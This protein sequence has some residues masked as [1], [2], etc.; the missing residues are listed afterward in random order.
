MLMAASTCGAAIGTVIGYVQIN[1]P[2]NKQAGGFN[3]GLSTVTTLCFDD[4]TCQSTVSNGS[5]SGGTTYIRNGYS[6]RFNQNFSVTTTTG[7][8][9]AIFVFSYQAPGIAFGASPNGGV[10]E[11][12]TTLSS[13]ALSAFTVENSSP[14]TTLDFKR[15]GSSIFSY[16]SPSPTGGSQNYTDTS[17]LTNTATYNAT[18]GD[19]TGT[20]T[21]NSVTFTYVYPFYYGVGAQSLTG[22]QVQALTKLVQIP[23]NTQTTTSPSSQV[24]Y[25]AYPQSAGSLISILDQNGFETINGY[26]KRSVTLTMLD[27]S[28]QPYF[29]Y[30]FNTLTTQTNFKNTYKFN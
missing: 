22:T 20:T 10:Y 19:G 23:A 11:L 13:I 15:N 14:I 26:T 2:N 1:P 28:S 29:I 30:E 3:V 25:F 8:L 17:G 5:S 12:G 9:D 4:G 16:P 21:S 24:Y 7:A 18:V 27:S 6:S